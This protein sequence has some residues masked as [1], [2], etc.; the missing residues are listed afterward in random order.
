MADDSMMVTREI[1]VKYVLG[2]LCFS[3]VVSFEKPK[4]EFTVST[5]GH[6]I[7]GIL[8]DQSTIWLRCIP[9]YVS[10]KSCHLLPIKI[11][12]SGT[13][14]PGIPT[15][16]YTFHWPRGS[17]GGNISKGKPCWWEMSHGPQWYQSPLADLPAHAS[18]RSKSTKRLN[19]AKHQNCHYG[20]GNAKVV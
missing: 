18:C 10:I 3:W 20:G 9:G 4:L 16:R 5:S 19:M 15:W 7:G 8:Q 13:G 2:V 1:W 11:Y 17:G 12:K 6:P 14:Y